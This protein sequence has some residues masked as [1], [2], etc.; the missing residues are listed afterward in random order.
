MIGDHICLRYFAR[1]FLLE[2]GRHFPFYV[3]ELKVMQLGVVGAYNLHL[4]ESNKA[5]EN[6]FEHCCLVILQNLVKG[7]IYPPAQANF[8]NLVLRTLWTF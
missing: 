7:S 4:E 2:N 3:S 6:P 5:E 8:A 1:L